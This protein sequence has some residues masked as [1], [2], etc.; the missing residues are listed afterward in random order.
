MVIFNTDKMNELKQKFM[1][2]MNER[3][4]LPSNAPAEIKDAFA[5]YQRLGREQ[6][7]YAYS[8]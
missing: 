4:Q 5:E 7:E 8:L 1:P 6:M 3:Y 2:Y